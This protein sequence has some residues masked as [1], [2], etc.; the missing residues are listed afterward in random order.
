MVT[1]TEPKTFFEEQGLSVILVAAL[2]MIL[3]IV[4]L[5]A[6]IAVCA[7]RYLS[8]ASQ[9]RTNI[10]AQEEEIRALRAI[11]SEATNSQNPVSSNA[12]E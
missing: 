12:S 8:K 1:V 9:D 3:C 7:L 11:I 4:L 10:S 6:C 5:I 2:G